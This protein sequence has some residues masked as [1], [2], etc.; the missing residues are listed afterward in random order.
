MTKHDLT[1]QFLKETYLFEEQIE[2]FEAGKISRNEFKG[3]SGG[4]GSYA[5]KEGGYML[6]LRLPAGRITKE[7]LKFIV[8]RAD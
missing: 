4:F 8:E 3:I 6:R 2:A 5:Q 7:T 1:E